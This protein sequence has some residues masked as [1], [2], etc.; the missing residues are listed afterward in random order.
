LTPPA[1]GIR[2]GRYERLHVP[3][4]AEILD[5]LRLLEAISNRGTVEEFKLGYL[6]ETYDAEQDVEEDNE[7][8]AAQLVGTAATAGNE[9]DGA[10]TKEERKV[11]NVAGHA[12]A[13][14]ARG[15]DDG[16][17][18]EIVEMSGLVVSA[19]TPDTLI[20][21]QPLPLLQPA[22]TP[23]A[24]SL[25]NDEI[26]HNEEAE[27]QQQQQRQKKRQTLENAVAEEERKLSTCANK[28][29]R[30]R[31]EGALRSLRLELAQLD[32]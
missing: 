10:D 22:T 3:S 28:I 1:Q 27:K 12:I 29:L 8:E 18:E 26:A 30:M 31:I 5:T 32:C 21:P 16:D 9:T 15:G 19:P 13:Q 14:T 17:V 7:N 11:V 4:E 23:V 24:S 6:T 2:T 25:V 20:L